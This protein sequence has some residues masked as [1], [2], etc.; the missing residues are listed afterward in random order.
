MKIQCACGSYKTEEV[1]SYRELI[2][3]NHLLDVEVKHTE[4]YH[5]GSKFATPC[6]LNYNVSQSDAA[7]HQIDH[8]IATELAGNPL[9]EK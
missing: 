5:C 7:R 2:Y 9:Y 8:W 6:Q 3:R 1:T 4:C